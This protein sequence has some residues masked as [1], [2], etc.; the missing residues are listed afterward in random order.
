[1]ADH[2]IDNNVTLEE[3]EYN[4]GIYHKYVMKGFIKND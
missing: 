3:L 1:M 2:I 4:V